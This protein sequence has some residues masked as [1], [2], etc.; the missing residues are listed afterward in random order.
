MN[1]LVHREVLEGGSPGL[2]ELEGRVGGRV[3]DWVGN[4]DF[5]SGDRPSILACLPDLDDVGPS[6]SYEAGNVHI[7]A[8]AETDI[9]VWDVI[10]G[11]WHAVTK[12]IVN[13]YRAL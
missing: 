6:A 11:I 10:D 8:H 13:N 12:V 4:G 2:W 9:L 5:Q 7:D 1:F 3:G